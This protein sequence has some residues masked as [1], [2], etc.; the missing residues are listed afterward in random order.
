MSYDL[1]KKSG[2][3][4]SL[5]NSQ[6]RFLLD[7][8]RENGW[9][10]DGV[11]DL[12]HGEKFFYDPYTVYDDYFLNEGLFV[13]D[14]DAIE[15]AEALKKALYTIPRS[16]DPIEKIKD[17]HTRE[18]IQLLRHEGIP[19]KYDANDEIDQI[20]LKEYMDAY[21]KDDYKK[22]N[23]KAREAYTD[24][25]FDNAYLSSVQMKKFIDFCSSGGFTIN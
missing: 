18:V 11:I 6:W 13:T 19:L 8:A 4:F 16:I 3:Y 14:R 23:D 7:L 20:W 25:N 21:D 15:L 24:K 22:M 9:K 1:M 5:S 17:Q 2:E 10:P 12:K